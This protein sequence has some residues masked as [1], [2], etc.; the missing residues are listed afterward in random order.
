MITSVYT[1]RVFSCILTLRGAA[2][3]LEKAQAEKRM[4]NTALVSAGGQERII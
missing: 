2:D 3:K 4:E 1:W